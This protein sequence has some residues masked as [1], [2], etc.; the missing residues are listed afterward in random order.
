LTYFHEIED[1]TGEANILSNLGSIYFMLGNSTKAIGA[2]LLNPF[3]KLS[4]ELN[5]KIKNRHF[6]Q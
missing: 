6:F 2:T 1:K 5:N 4:E 3:G